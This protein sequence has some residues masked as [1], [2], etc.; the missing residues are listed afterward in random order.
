MSFAKNRTCL[1]SICKSSPSLYCP[2]RDTCVRQVAVLQG[3]HQVS[4]SVLKVVTICNR[5][6]A[7]DSVSVFKMACRTAVVIAYRLVFVSFT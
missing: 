5:S 2:C 6:M 7:V 1:L 3:K 4:F